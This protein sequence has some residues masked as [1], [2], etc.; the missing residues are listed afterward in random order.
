MA[1]ILSWPHA[2]NVGFCG[3]PYIPSLGN[4]LP[5]KLPACTVSTG[6]VWLPL[7]LVLDDVYR[8]NCCSKSGEYIMYFTDIRYVFHVI[9]NQC[10]GMYGSCEKGYVK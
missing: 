1:A 2:L 8:T 10:V 3:L 9:F 6:R 5:S 7:S 4:T